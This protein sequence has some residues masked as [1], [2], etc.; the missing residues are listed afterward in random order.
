MG[1]FSDLGSGGGGGGGGEEAKK[2]SENDYFQ[3]FFFNISRTKTV[4][5]VKLTN[6]LY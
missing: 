5:L 4:K 6:S 2:P 3:N 1:F